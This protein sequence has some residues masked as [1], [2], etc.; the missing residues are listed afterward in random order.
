M[1]EPLLSQVFPHDA[2]RKHEL[3]VIDDADGEHN[4][5]EQDEPN[6]EMGHT[7]TGF[8]IL[9]SVSSSTNLNIV[10]PKPISA[11]D[12]RITAS[13]VRSAL[14][15][16]RCNAR[17]V[18]REAISNELPG[19]FDVEVTRSSVMTIFFMLKFEHGRATR[20]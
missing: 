1:D 10:N 12:V 19:G 3:R 15:R 8:S 6:A 4:D 11:R 14:K 7:G 16:V 5:P 13:S 9:L 20:V 17:P 2:Q 18:F